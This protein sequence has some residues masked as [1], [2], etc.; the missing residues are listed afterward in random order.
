MNL[1][2]LEAA[3]RGLGVLQLGE[4]FEVGGRPLGYTRYQLSLFSYF[5][6]GFLIF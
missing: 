6:E 2:P 5:C 1:F 4:N 3:I